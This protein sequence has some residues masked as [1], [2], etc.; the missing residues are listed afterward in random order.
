MA[1]CSSGLS[2]SYAYKKLKCRCSICLEW[3]RTTRLRE[4]PELNKERARAWRIKNPE[5]SRA[6]VKAWQEKNPDNVLKSKLK[7]YGLTLE[8]YRQ[9]VI[10]AGNKCWICGKPPHGMQ[11]SL[12]RLCIDHDKISGKF[13]GLLCGNC[14][15]A[16]GLFD[17]NSK[18][19]RR[20][21]DYLDNFDD[22]F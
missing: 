2:P 17:H 21:V 16:L 9:L 22:V 5:R 4:D 10:E 8:Q 18:S 15:A 1:Q 12:D 3:K 6:S 11:Y 20:A 14:N 13:R 7:S 19:L